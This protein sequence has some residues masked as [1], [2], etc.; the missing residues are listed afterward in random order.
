MNRSISD[1]DSV[2][3]FIYLFILITPFIFSIALN[4][5][6]CEFTRCRFKTGVLLL[7]LTSYI[8]KHKELEVQEV[9]MM[10]IKAPIIIND[11]SKL[12]LLLL[13]INKLLLW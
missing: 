6:L 11:D 7:F 10:K 4:A 13:L 12:L 5:V 2:V 8:R 9:L 1:S 3:Y